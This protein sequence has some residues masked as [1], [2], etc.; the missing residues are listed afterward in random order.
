MDENSAGLAQSAK[1]A[2]TVGLIIIAGATAHATQTASRKGKDD[3]P[4]KFFWVDWLI[5]LPLGAFS[6]LLFA[7]AAQVVTQDPTHQYLAAA[8]GSILGLKGVNAITVKVLD[9]LVE[10]FFS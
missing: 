5:A 2:L 1:D 4:S 7:L 6:G 3:E 8:A 9:K 10:K